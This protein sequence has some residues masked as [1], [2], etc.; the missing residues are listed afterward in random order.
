MCDICHA[1]LCMGIQN[2]CSVACLSQTEPIATYQLFL[3]IKQLSSSGEDTTTSLAFMA[4]F[5]ASD[6]L[7]SI[8]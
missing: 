8:I 3:Y 2:P 5:I 6:P 7:V 4:R 1:D